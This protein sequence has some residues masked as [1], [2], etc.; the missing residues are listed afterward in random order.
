M[1][2]SAPEDPQAAAAA[3][4]GQAAAIASKAES[5]AH[6]AKDAQT[7]RRWLFLGGAVAVLGG[8]YALLRRR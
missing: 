8:A 4:A 7:K 3:A 5:D 2:L 6:A 1:Y